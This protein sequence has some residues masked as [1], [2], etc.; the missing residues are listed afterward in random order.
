M[1]NPNEK[2]ID[3]TRCSKCGCD[4][5]QARTIDQTSH[6]YRYRLP[7]AFTFRFVHSKQ[8]RTGFSACRSIKPPR[9]GHQRTA[10]HV[11][12]ATVGGC[13]FIRIDVPEGDGFR[14][15]FYGNGAI[16][17]M[18]PVSE[19]IARE[20][21]RTHSSPPV[22]PYEVSSLLKRLQPAAEDA[23]ADESSEEPLW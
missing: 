17:S 10:G 1:K 23:D 12:E 4:R 13:A 20:I 5:D 15:E 2:H 9:F 21:V 14:T 6:C 18:R 8:V 16:Y 22:S 11:T 3:V 19:D 7:S